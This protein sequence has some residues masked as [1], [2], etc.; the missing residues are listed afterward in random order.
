MED[1]Y[2]LSTQQR[3]SKHQQAFNNALVKK[4]R[5]TA[6]AHD[7]EFDE[8]FTDKKLRDRWKAGMKAAADQENTVCK[9]SGIVVTADK[10][11]WK[12]ADLAP[13]INFCLETFPEYRCCFGGDWP[14]STLKS[15]FSQRV[16]ALKQ[17]VADRSPAFQQQLSFDYAV[18]FY[19]FQA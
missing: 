1:Y 13:N 7:F 4:V 14:V 3:Q 10:D 15:S 11:K 9:I 17:L 18:N 12:P 19:R 6:Q 2:E 5:A 16:T 8:F